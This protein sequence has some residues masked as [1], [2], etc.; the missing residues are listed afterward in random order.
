MASTTIERARGMM[1]RARNGATLDLVLVVGLG[2]ALIALAFFVAARFVKPAPRFPFA[3]Q[4]GQK[5][6]FRDDR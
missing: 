4:I 3:I 6:N 1:Q 2:L 5:A